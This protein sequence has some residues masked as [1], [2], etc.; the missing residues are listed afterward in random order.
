MS[1]TDDFTGTSGDYLE[2]RTG[3]TLVDGAAGAAQINASNQLK[4]TSTQSVG[5]YACTDQGSSDHYTQVDSYDTGNA[6][7]AAV[8]MTDGNN[9]IIARYGT[10]QWQLF[11]R[12]SGSFT[13]LGTYTVSHTPGD[14]LYLEADSSDNITV[15]INGTA[16]IGPVSET[17][18]NT[19]TQQGLY[20]RSSTA[21]PWIDNFEAGALAVGGVA[22]PWYYYAQH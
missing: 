21:D 13:S 19:E 7:P 9:G 14:T 3:W 10:F 2:S 8:R 1:F 22:N 15:K 16:R 4:N 17:F 18:N 5:S 12:V 20:P 11:K 6:F